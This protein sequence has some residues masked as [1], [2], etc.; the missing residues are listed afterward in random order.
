VDEEVPILICVG[1]FVASEFDLYLAI[2]LTPATLK[3]LYLIKEKKL[4]GGVT[5]D[6]KPNDPLGAD[7]I[8]LF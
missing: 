7:P 4:T 8:V 6:F 2:V 5:N 3:I 1:S